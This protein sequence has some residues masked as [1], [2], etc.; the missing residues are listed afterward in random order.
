MA[1]MAAVI[2][3]DRSLAGLLGS[4]REAVRHSAGAPEVASVETAPCVGANARS[5]PGRAAACHR[6]WTL[7][8]FTTPR[9]TDSMIRWEGCNAIPGACL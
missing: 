4:S 1:A 7:D 5:V 9:V 8:A 2:H 3:G 6:E